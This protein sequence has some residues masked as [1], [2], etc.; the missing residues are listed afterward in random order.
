MKSIREKKAAIEM[1]IGTIV[2]IVIAVTMLIFGIV[3]VR[4]IMCGAINLTS[5]LNSNVNKEIDKLF[6]STGGEV[7]CVGS[8]AEPIDMIPGRYNI[9]YCGIKAPETKDYTITVTAVKP[10]I[11]TEATVRGWITSGETSWTGIVAPGDDAPK[12]ILTLNVPDNAAEE[13]I[14]ISVEIKKAG[15][16]ISQQDLDFVTKRAGVIRSALC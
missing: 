6:G 8:G 4:N 3:F 14:R 9:V 12:K 15:Q 7:S 13:N 10:S 5:G 11:D 2:I 1:S 16:V